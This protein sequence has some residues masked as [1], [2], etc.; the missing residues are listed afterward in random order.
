MSGDYKRFKKATFEALDAELSK[1][2]A[3]K[4]MKSLIFERL[5]SDCSDVENGVLA[6]R[7]PPSV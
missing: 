6:V 5:K 2:G 3:T 4:E 1:S 7:D